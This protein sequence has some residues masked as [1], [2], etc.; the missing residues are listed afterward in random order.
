[1][2]KNFV[3]SR[4]MARLWHYL[5]VFGTT[6]FNGIVLWH[7]IS[8][9]L[10]FLASEFL[11]VNIKDLNTPVNTPL[12]ASINTQNYILHSTLQC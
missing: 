9:Y 2:F 11:W 5:Y 6:W 8:N 4:F 7:P 3:P 12:N 1:M 10:E